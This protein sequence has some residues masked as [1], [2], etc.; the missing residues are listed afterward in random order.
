MQQLPAGY[1]VVLMGSGNVAWHFGRALQKAGAEI[2]QVWSR[3]E[4][5]SRKLARSLKAE[6]VWGDTAPAA[7]AELY[8]IAVKDNAIG[9][10]AA[11]IPK[12]I[13]LTVHTAGSIPVEILQDAKTKYTGII[14]PVQSLTSGKRTNLGKVPMCIEAGNKAGKKAVKQIAAALSE[15][16]FELDWRQREAAHLAAVFA[17]NFSNHLF[18][19]AEK[20][21]AE[22]KVPFDVLRPLIAETAEKVQHLSPA[23]AQ[24]GPAKR[25]DKQVMQKH[26]QLLNAHPELQKIYRLLS[27]SI[28]KQNII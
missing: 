14:W 27:T 11:K 25:G 5:T 19:L 4:A 20:L 8:L 2:I 22:N 15:H 16:V 13:G 21:A 7:G 24:T 3:N 18:A 17:N 10:V 9:S 1:K 12:G 26:I 28:Q 23:L 6:P